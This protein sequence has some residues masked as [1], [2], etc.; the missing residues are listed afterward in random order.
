MDLKATERAWAGGAD[1]PEDFTGYAFGADSASFVPVQLPEHAAVVAGV[2]AVLIDVP[3]PPFRNPRRDRPRLDGGDADT[4]RGQLPARGCG[5]AFDG[6]FSGDVGGAEAE[7]KTPQHGS[8][9][10]DAAAT[11]LAG[12]GAHGEQEALREI[13]VPE[14]VDLE[15]TFQGF[16]WQ[17][18][19]G[20]G[21]GFAGVVHYHC[22]ATVVGTAKR[23]MAT[24]SRIP[25][26]VS[27]VSPIY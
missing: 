13:D 26:S 20:A 21:L 7:G 5:E 19:E 12:R 2:G 23:F 18:L 4:V 6:G 15:E 24:V 22:G 17:L 1:G 25:L 3:R 9:H 27:C 14:H 8:D 11:S 10:D 16:A